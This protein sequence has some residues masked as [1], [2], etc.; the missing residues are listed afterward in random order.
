MKSKVY[1]RLVSLIVAFSMIFTIDTMQINATQIYDEK[2]DIVMTGMAIGE[3]LGNPGGFLLA[4]T[5][6]AAKVY[7]DK[8]HEEI[9]EGEGYEYCGLEIIAERFAGDVELVT[10]AVPAV[11]T[12]ASEM[13]GNMIIAGTVGNNDVINA[14][15]NNGV[16][17]ISGLYSNNVLKWDCYQMQF[18]SGADMARCGYSGVSQALVIT[19]SN[20]RGAM[21]GLFNI[22]EHIGVSAWVYMADAVPI[23]YSQVFLDGALLEFNQPDKYLAKEPSV[24]YRGFFI[25]DEAPSFTGWASQAFGGL[26]ENL[27]ENVF[28]LIIRMKAN[29]MWPAM[30]GN[31]FSD[32][33]KAFKLA[34]VV[35]AD[36]YGVCMGTSHHEA[37][38]RAGVEW[39]RVYR[40]YGSSNA[41]DYEENEEAIYEFWKEGIERNG[42]YESTLT[43]GMRGEGD[44]ALKGDVEYNINLLKK[45]ISDQNEIIDTYET[46][47]P[48]SKIKDALKIYIPYSEN[49]EFYYGPDDGSIDGLNVWDGMDDVTIL[50]TDD[51]YGNIR[52]LPEESVRYREAG[53]GLYYHLD[54]HVGTG[55]Y[56]WVSSTQLEHIW[57][58]LT[59]AYDYNVKNVW[60]INVGDIK[61]V[62]MELNYCMDLAYD[63]EKWGQPNTAKTYREQWLQ[64][65]LGG[66]SNCPDDVAT[67]VADCVADFLKISTYRKPE[68]V[69]SDMYSVTN[70][71]EIQEVLDLCVKT[72]EKANYY[73][74]NYFKGTQWDDAY[75]QI[76]YYQAVGTANVTMMQIFKG[77]NDFFVK[78]N[79]SL[80][81][82]YASYVEDAIEYDKELTNYYNNEMTGG[83]WHNMMSSPHVGFKTWN[84]DGWSYPSPVRINLEADAKMLV[85][86]EGSEN[87]YE[88]GVAKLDT[89]TNTEKQRYC[90]TMSNA[91]KEAYDFTV[92]TRA[93]WIQITDKYG[94]QVV[95][96]GTVSDA[97]YFYVSVDWTKVRSEKEG[98]VVI[99][100]A[101]ET[102]KL[103][104]NTSYTEYKSKGVRTHFESND[105]ITIEAEEYIDNVSSSD[106]VSWSCIDGYGRYKSAMKMFPTTVSFAKSMGYD[107]V[108]EEKFGNYIRPI[109]EYYEP[110]SAPY[111]EYQIYVDEEDDY[112]FT[113]YTTPTNNIFKPADWGY[114]PVDL[115]YGIC[116]DDGYI[117]M[118]NSL[119]SG[120]YISYAADG[121]NNWIRGIK[122]NIHVSTS[123]E[124]LTQ[125]LHKVRFYGMHAG[126]AL[127]RLVISNKELKS[128]YL[129]PKDTFMLDYDIIPE[130]KAGVNYEAAA[131]TLSYGAPADIDAITD[132]SDKNDA[133]DPVEIETP[134][135]RP[136]VPTPAPVIAPSNN[137]HTGNQTIDTADMVEKKLIKGKVIK[138]GKLK[139]KITKLT[140]KSG[141]I[142]G[143]TVSVSGVADKKIRK[144]AKKLTIPKTVKLSGNTVYGVK[145]KVNE[146]GKKA[147]KGCKKLKTVTVKSTVIKKVDKTAFKGISGKVKVKVPKQ[148]RKSYKKIFR[149]IQVK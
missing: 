46:N 33:G 58:Q 149:N 146:I 117:Q 106:G 142:T 48:D 85:T 11:V 74:D 87:A 61:P 30:W 100:G 14:L 57:D 42:D 34:N 76:V 86:P 126:L 31:S 66:K 140:V 20:K 44:S 7:I 127:E 105:V 10:G 120:K 54:G 128:S 70:Y 130:Q 37:C 89:F 102:V 136:Y 143:G 38:C 64:K 75:Y 26:N 114:V 94:N 96:G 144:N 28:E 39:Q 27:Y 19:G 137:N 95:N 59:M 79:S 23:K 82:V 141:R 24:K 68:Y 115:Y 63:M 129:G 77:L 16:I 78:Q 21:Y 124:H 8:S 111:M 98:T 56:E 88:T 35:L 55:A 52:S 12:N 45:I 67:G 40:N 80:A 22:S 97:A 148:K 32:E 138:A 134:I 108:S 133:A 99:K 119:P 36:A 107:Y 90:I 50:M 122:D 131:G 13:T 6:T 41:W 53:W 1:K 103:K 110:V 91:G 47:N 69:A 92:G 81:N 72:I 83:K 9:S 139:Y 73:Y 93:E 49:E 62:E 116:V 51:N 18:V 135:L 60:V 4:D 125:G 3:T 104:V 71:N 145:F 112:T 132:V 15:V 118:V 65:Q 109:T 84:S 29:Y 113:A 147:F 2:E 25:N 101:D 121:D 43:M 123:M 5:N 17:D